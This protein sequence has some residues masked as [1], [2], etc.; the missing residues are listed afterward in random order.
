MTEKIGLAGTLGFLTGI[1]A[2]TAA[3]TLLIPET[4]GLS[5]DQIEQG[6]V[7]GDNVQTLL[8]S[9]SSTGPVSPEIEAK[10][11]VFDKQGPGLA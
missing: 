8:G 2:L 9:G 7:F 5:L 10:E 11:Q 6:V 4:K 3:A 1:M